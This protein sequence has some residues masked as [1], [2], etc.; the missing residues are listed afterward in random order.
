ML[1]MSDE[2]FRRFARTAAIPRAIPRASKAW[3]TKETIDAVARAA[4]RDRECIA[5]GRPFRWYGQR[6]RVTCGSR[7]AARLRRSGPLR[8]RARRSVY[9]RPVEACQLRGWLRTLWETRAAAPPPAKGRYLASGDA[10]RLAGIASIQLS[11][12]HRRGFIRT[13]P[14]P[15]ARWHGRP[16]LL[17]HRGDLELAGR[18]WRAEKVRRAAAAGSVRHI[19]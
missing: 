18:V 1:G 11:Y 19:V 16:R 4:G 10:L 7:C 6:H 3:Y 5:C 14:H 2:T 12:L 8:R 13:Q 9:E 15:T 17:Y